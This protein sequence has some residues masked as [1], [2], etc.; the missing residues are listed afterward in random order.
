MKISI[1]AIQE[2][3]QQF[4]KYGNYKRHKN[5]YNRTKR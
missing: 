3:K 4:K 1:L 5:N 2:N